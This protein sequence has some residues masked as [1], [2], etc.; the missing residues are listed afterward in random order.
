MISSPTY[1]R[2]HYQVDTPYIF[3]FLSSPIKG[4]RWRSCLRNWATSQKVAVS[5]SD[6]VVD[7]ILLAALWCL[8]STRPL[9]EMNTRNISW[10]VK[11]CQ[12]V[13]LTI[14]PNSCADSLEIWKLRTRWTLR[15][16]P[17]LNR[18]CFTFTFIFT[19]HHQQQ[20]EK[21]E[22]ALNRCIACFTMKSVDISS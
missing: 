11:C 16:C 8:G 17:G 9:T 10:E 2:L 5:I 6:G 12:C 21:E 18:D 13:W 14:L 15:A 7:I 3:G 19:Y 22:E 1:I 20:H 4:T